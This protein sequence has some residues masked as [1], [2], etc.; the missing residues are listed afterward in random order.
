MEGR[1]GEQVAALTDH[2]HGLLNHDVYEG[3][4]D[5]IINTCVGNIINVLLYG[6][7]YSFKDPKFR[8]MKE[9]LESNFKLVSSPLALLIQQTFW[10]RHLPFFRATFAAIDYS[11]K[12]ISNYL[13]Q[14]V[15]AIAREYDPN[16]EPTNYCEAYLQVL[17]FATLLTPTLSAF[18]LSHL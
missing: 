16:Q 8:R 6:K 9:L 13:L 10:L 5:L 3:P 2:I 7:A 11:N 18:K 12:T 15:R 1:I 17:T 14:D 4:L